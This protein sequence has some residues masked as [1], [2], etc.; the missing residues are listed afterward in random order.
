MTVQHANRFSP[1]VLGLL[2]LCC[3]S[4]AHADRIV[5]TWICDSGNYSTLTCWAPKRGE[6]P[7]NRNSDIF[8]VIIPA[9]KGTVTIDTGLIAYEV[10]SLTLGQGRTFDVLAGEYAV[11]G[12]ADID[13]AI[14]AHG[15]EFLAPMASLN[16]GQSLLLASKGGQVV[17]GATSLCS[18]GHG[19]GVYFLHSDGSDTKDPNRFSTLHLSG[20]TELDDR[21][22]DDL[23]KD[24]WHGIKVTSKGRIDLSG[25]KT[26]TGPDGDE[27]LYV[28]VWSGGAIDMNSLEKVEGGTGRVC[29]RVGGGGPGTLTLGNVTFNANTFLTLKE[30]SKLE[31]KSL[32]AKESTTIKFEHADDCLTVTGE[33]CLGDKITIEN[34]G[35]ASLVLGGDFTHAHHCLPSM[36]GPTQVSLRESRVRF[37]GDGPQEVEVGG[38]DAGVLIDGF[39]ND[40][41]GYGQM[42]VGRDDPNAGPSAVFLVDHANNSNT[43]GEPVAEKEALYL[44]GKDSQ[45]GLRLLNG[46]ILYMN[47]LK[48]YAKVGGVM[49]DLTTLFND[50]EMVPFDGGYLCRS[51]PDVNDPRNLIDKDGF[52]VGVGTI[53]QVM[54]TEP[55][56]IYHVWFDLAANPL[57]DAE[58]EVRVSVMQ[59]DEEFAFE[60]FVAPQA[61]WQKKTW[62]FRAKSEATRLVFVGSEDANK[63]FSVSIDDVIVLPNA[64]AG[65]VMLLPE[66]GSVTPAAGVRAYPCGEVVS[67]TAAPGPYCK[68]VKW[69]G[70]AVDAGRIDPEDPTS[71]EIRVTVDNW[72]TLRAI[73]DCR[74]CSVTISTTDGGT[75]DPAPGK[76]EHLRGTV[77]SVVALPNDT[78][79]PFVRWKGTAVDAGKV[80]PNGTSAEISVTLD[81][82]YTLTAVFTDD[83]VIRDFPFDRDPGWSRTGEWAFG[84]PQGK[85][86]GE[87]GCPDPVGGYT[88]PNVFGVNL[89]GNY[90]STPG[91]M[92]SLIAGP[93]DLSNYKEVRLRFRRWLNTDEPAFVKVGINTSI[94]KTVWRPEPLWQHTGSSPITDCQWQEVEY[95]LGSQADGQPAVYLQWWYQVLQERPYSYSGWNLDDIQLIG[96]CK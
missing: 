36:G 68:F 33:F 26:I 16:G 87:H 89:D 60:K 53:S 57:P 27:Y 22:S 80:E 61:G 73:S 82:R 44:F 11:L 9:G 12:E 86:G 3:V 88:G 39:A 96:K 69:E 47:G 1:M 92:C 34:P 30:G 23:N 17:I 50:T 59:G 81:D 20:V 83:V 77:V 5:S 6:P 35:K 51:C 14:H 41:F 58:K 76:Q 24:S 84:P 74:P 48:V 45:D 46:S 19:N 32:Q 70:T 78:C 29:F 91:L 67:V 62:R 49:A 28:D 71:P 10:S 64:R 72:Y 94:G 8:D 31:T 4:V 52:E 40:N 79:H 56:A 55:N 85:G 7:F 25:L 2:T 95:P 54:A 90:V 21:F 13:G 15:G 18:T 65:L 43:P 66:G 75:T 63:P 38:Y 93:F 42:T 37:N